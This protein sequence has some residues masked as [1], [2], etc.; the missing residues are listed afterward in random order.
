MKILNLLLVSF[1]IS[2][3]CYA[4]YRMNESLRGHVGPG[5]PFRA[6]NVDSERLENDMRAR[7]KHSWKMFQ[8]VTRPVRTKSRIIVPLFDTWYDEEEFAK[9][10]KKLFSSLSPEEQT[11]RVPFSEEQ[12]EAA[13]ADADLG[14]SARRW[15]PKKSGFRQRKAHQLP[16]GF[17]GVGR[18][19]FSPEFLK[20]YLRHY[21][22]VAKCTNRFITTVPADFIPENP[23]NFTICFDEE[24]PVDAV[25]LKTVWIEKGSSAMAFKSDETVMSTI[26]SQ[27]VFD[28]PWPAKKL[29]SNTLGDDDI[30]TVKTS[31]GTFQLYAMHVVSKEVRQWVWSTFWWSPEANSN[32][33]EDRPRHLHNRFAGWNHYNMCTAVDF[34]EHDSNPGRHYR[35]SHPS[36]SRVLSAVSKEMGT[37][38]QCANPYL[39]GLFA[40]TNCIGCHQNSPLPMLFE[41]QQ[42][43]NNFP[44]DF[45][46]SFDTFRNLIQMGMK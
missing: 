40:K 43:R 13:I 7:R 37:A 9:I 24:F 30:F 2:R 18:T 45:P 36:L 29:D 14:P 1:L 4:E 44:S 33:G 27:P 42:V 32:F 16:P 41:T 11:K 35:R 8:Q 15:I 20:H 23:E 34:V 28:Q 25:M 26:L 38:T 6:R 46:Y 17:S 31:Y 39:E 5:Q 22:Q 3:N 21:A 19:L 12:I 10:F